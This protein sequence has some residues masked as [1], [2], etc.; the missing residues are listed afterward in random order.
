MA[1]IHSESYWIVNTL[2]L[3]TKMLEGNDEHMHTVRHER[4]YEKLH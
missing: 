2:E 4:Y 3:K 1:A